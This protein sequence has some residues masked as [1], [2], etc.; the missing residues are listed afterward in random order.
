MNNVKL[1][2]VLKGVLIKTFILQIL[3]FVTL[4]FFTLNFKFLILHNFSPQ[5]QK[6]RMF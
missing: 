5:W 4:D 3:L 2:G 1:F 6:T